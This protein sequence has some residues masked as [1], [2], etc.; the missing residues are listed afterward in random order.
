MASLATFMPLQFDTEVQYVK[1]VG[2]KLGDILFRRGIH[3]VQDLLEYYPRTYEDRR[4]IRQ[5]QSLVP[6]QLVS[7]K[8]QILKIRSM[9]MGKSKRRIWEV[10]LGDAT[11]RIACKY[12]RV[13]YKGYFERFQPFQEV[14]VIGK[15]TNYRGVKEFHHPDLHAI[16]EE[17]EISNALIPI[18][19]EIEGVNS[20]KISRLIKAVLDQPIPEN[21]PP[22]YLEK[23]G[24][25]PLGKALQ[26]VHDPPVEQGDLFLKFEAP[27][28]RRLIF[29]EFFL[30]ELHL[31]GKR[32]GIEKEKSQAILS[33]GAL[34]EKLKASLEFELT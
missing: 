34:A 7:L 18:Y 27:A 15:V 5:I 20:A 23:Y 30:I 9:P 31:A 4:A 11:G 13:P 21:L 19:T 3:K 29:D 33:S 6:D 25:M 22:A 2:P 17:D 28:Q 26:E 32:A 12:F 10:L 8:A 16:K 24:L 14:R 1:G